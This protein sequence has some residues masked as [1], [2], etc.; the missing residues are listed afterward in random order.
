MGFEIKY[1]FHEKKD[2]G[3][4]NLEEKK[5]FKRSLGDPFEE[6]D[7][8]EL[9]SAILKQFGRR[10]V[11][12]VDVDIVELIRK[13]VSFKEA[14]GGIILKNRKYSFDEEVCLNSRDVAQAV[15]PNMLQ[16]L[17]KLPPPMPDKPI[18]YDEEVQQQQQLAVVKPPKQVVPKLLGAKPI[19][20]EIYDPEPELFRA[21]RQRGLKFT[22]GGRYPIYEERRGDSIGLGFMYV[23]V[24]N[25]GN[26]QIIHGS[27][28]QPETKGLIGDFEPDRGFS[29][30]MSDMPA[31]R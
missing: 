4:Y 25:A 28:F 2:D 26:K 10:D 6:I 3:S 14:K 9:A 1:V 31:L 18:P 27:H 29:G 8:N 22:P 30:S 7:L 15:P 12:V 5:E 16:Y 19:R 24:D 21:A 20:Y 17:P 23:T 11:L 13:P